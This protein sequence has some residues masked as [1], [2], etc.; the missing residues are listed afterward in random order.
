M[1]EDETFIID[2]LRGDADAL[3]YLDL[4]GAGKPP[5]KISSST[6]LEVYEGLV[7]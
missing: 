2:I 7:R 6:V 1:I 5:E 3:E 4:L